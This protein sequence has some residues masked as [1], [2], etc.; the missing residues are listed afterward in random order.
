MKISIANLKKIHE[1]KNWIDSSFKQHVTIEGL[2]VNHG[3]TSQRFK[4]MFKQVFGV[5]PFDYLREVRM[6]EAKRL[7]KETDYKIDVVALEVGYATKQSLLNAFKKALK[8]S[9]GEY[10]KSTFESVNGSICPCCGRP[11]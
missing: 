5:K 3:L 1:A 4:P 11:L 7:L 8:M 9:P 2:A 6:K 10:R